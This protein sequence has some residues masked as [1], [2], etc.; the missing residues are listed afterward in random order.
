MQE[1]HEDAAAAHTDRGDVQGA[2]RPRIHSFCDSK[3]LAGETE[4]HQ[5]ESKGS[6]LLTQQSEVQAV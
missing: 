4:E 6:I 1:Q 3:G 2:S 5:D